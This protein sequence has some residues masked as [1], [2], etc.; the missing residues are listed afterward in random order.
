[1]SKRTWLIWSFAIS[2]AF[3]YIKI[4]TFL[5]IN[6]ENDVYIKDKKL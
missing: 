3:K 5:W 4:S 2:W 1:M 6:L